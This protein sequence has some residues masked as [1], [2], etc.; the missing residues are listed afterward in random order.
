MKRA[1][2]KAIDF[3]YNSG[4]FDFEEIAEMLELEEGQVEEIYYSMGVE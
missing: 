1:V 2:Y 4:G 3:L